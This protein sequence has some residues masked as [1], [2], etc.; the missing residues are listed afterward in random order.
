MTYTFPPLRNSWEQIFIG[1]TLVLNKC[2]TW[3]ERSWEPM[4]SRPASNSLRLREGSK[5]RSGKLTDPFQWN[6]FSPKNGWDAHSRNWPARPFHHQEMSQS[7]PLSLF[8]IKRWANVLKNCPPRHLVKVKKNF[9]E[10]EFQWNGSVS[11]KIS[12]KIQT[13]P[14]DKKAWGWFHETLR[15][16]N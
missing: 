8:T 2:L 9:G 3:S 10:S 7:W 13:F 6:S 16:H 4:T 1:E 14:T 15:I 5:F 12:F 11:W